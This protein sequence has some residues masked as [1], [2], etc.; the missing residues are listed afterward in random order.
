MSRFN[1]GG[2]AILQGLTNV[3]NNIGGVIREN[4]QDSLLK[5]LLSR[6]E[7][8][9]ESAIAELAQADPRLA[10]F[11]SQRMQQGQAELAN[12]M[13]PMALE[14]QKIGDPAQ[15][16]AFLRAQAEGAPPRVQ[17]EILETLNMDDEQMLND[18]NLA[19]QSYT[20]FQAPKDTRTGDM[21]EYELARRQGFK[22]SFVDFQKQIKQAGAT[23]ISNTVNGSQSLP[24]KIPNGFMLKDA[25]D[26]SKGVTPI[27]G[28]NPDKSV[29]G[30]AGKI[31]MLRVAQEAYKNVEKLVFDE[32]GSLNQTNL[33][34]ALVNF[35][36]SDGRTINQKMEVGIQAITRLETGA[37]MPPE[38]VKNTRKRFQ[39]TIG[40]SD[41]QAK[42]KLELF[43]LFINGSLKLIDPSGRFD[44]ERFQEELN[45]RVGDDKAQNKTLSDDE[46]FKKYGIE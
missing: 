25:D 4:K 26:P 21:K 22:G 34:A 15:I 46:L 2:N 5:G 39:P 35:P 14:A 16:R 1:P 27:P 29:A 17:K 9:D 33:A 36:K 24:F 40:D 43:K 44:D 45:K 13:G 31:Q 23:N 30:D 8:G 42:E 38:E 28:S 6:V 18:I 41:K 10:T 20:G 12:K 37:A 19:A 32:D 11:I 7:K 3:G